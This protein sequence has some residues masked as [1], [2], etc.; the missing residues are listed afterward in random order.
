LHELL[1]F[2]RRHDLWVLSDE[3]Y[4]YFTHGA[5]HVSIMSLDPDDRVFSAFPSPRPAR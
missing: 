2:A 3:V 4:E 1:D 5:P